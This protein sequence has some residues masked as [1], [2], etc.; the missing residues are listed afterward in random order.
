M[1]KTRFY[2]VTHHE[3]D[4]ILTFPIEEQRAINFLHMREV[5]AI[6]GKTPRVGERVKIRSYPDGDKIFATVQQ[7]SPDGIPVKVQL[8]DGT[9]IELVGYLVQLIHL[10][11]AII[12]AIKEL[13]DQDQTAQ[14][15]Y[16]RASHGNWP[17]RTTLLLFILN[18]PIH[19]KEATQKA[20]RLDTHHY[21][22][23]DPLTIY[24][25]GRAQAA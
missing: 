3:E 15:T 7:V 24:R 22:S 5:I 18:L 23:N 20:I 13:F 6:R 16:S 25:T 9:I 14:L 8:E 19:A 4:V 2:E 12:I 17:E 11:E 10:I 1:R 21:F